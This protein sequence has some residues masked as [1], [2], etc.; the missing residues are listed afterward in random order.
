MNKIEFALDHSL[1]A[2]PHVLEE[3]EG[4]AAAA[5]RELLGSPGEDAT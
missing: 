4:A 3:Y 2:R 5:R 1:Q